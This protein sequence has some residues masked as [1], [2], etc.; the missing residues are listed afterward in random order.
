VIHRLARIQRI[1]RRRERVARMVCPETRLSVSPVS[2]A[3]SA[4]ISRV[5]RLLSYPNSLGERWSMP[6]KASALRS[7]KAAYTRLGVEEPSPKASRPFSLKVRMAF[8]T[9][10]EAHPRFSAILGGERPRALARRIWQRR[11]TK[12]SLERTPAWR[13]SRSFSDSSRTKNWRFHGG[14]YSPSRTQPSLIMH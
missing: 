8:L 2:K 10:C 1:P 7:S 12:A 3:A 14:N 5:H 6:R 13:P 11:I 9:V 4:A